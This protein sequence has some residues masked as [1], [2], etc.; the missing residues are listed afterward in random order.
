[1]HMSERGGVMETA[2]GE[3]IYTLTPE[4]LLGRPMNEIE[5]KYAPRKLHVAG[6]AKKIPL[7]GP[8]AAIIGSRKASSQGLKAASDIAKILVRRGVIVVSGL[9][10]GIDTLAHTATIEEGGQTIAV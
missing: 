1:M 6:D 4:E 10:E 9:A 3:K 8:R 7:S 5:N 2:K